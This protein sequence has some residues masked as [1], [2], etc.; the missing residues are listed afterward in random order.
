M[1]FASQ[2]YKLNS[3]TY[4]SNTGLCSIYLNYAGFQIIKL[5]EKHIKTQ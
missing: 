4:I 2:E 3:Y 5:L 1:T